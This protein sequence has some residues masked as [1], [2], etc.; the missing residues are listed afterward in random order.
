MAA[1]PRS[2]LTRQ[3]SPRSSFTCEEGLS[4]VPASLARTQR[5]P[6]PAS[7]RSA[8]SRPVPLDGI[9]RHLDRSVRFGRRYALIGPASAA[10]PSAGGAGAAPPPSSAKAT[11]GA[12]TTNAMTQHKDVARLLIKQHLTSVFFFSLGTGFARGPPLAS[13]QMAWVPLGPPPSPL[14][15]AAFA[16]VYVA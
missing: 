2:L 4:P 8:A 7:Q 9:G 10:S 14:P 6:P 3:S 5:R 13:S 11:A 1:G 12:I 15:W 16:Q